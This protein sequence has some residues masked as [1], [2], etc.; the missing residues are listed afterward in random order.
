MTDP[1]TIERSEL[2]N[3]VIVITQ[4]VLRELGIKVKDIK[5][6]ISQNQAHKIL[7][8]AKYEKALKL[9][10]IE[11]RKK[12]G[13]QISRVEVSRRDVEKLISKPIL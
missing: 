12:P 6:T 8:R 3:M 7:G 9:G 4:E 5:P 13:S 1:I 10:L 2:R 11:I